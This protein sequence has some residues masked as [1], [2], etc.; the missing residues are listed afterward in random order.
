MVS[1]ANS[2]S[3]SRTSCL[4][5]RGFIV[6]SE[7]VAKEDDAEVLSI[8]GRE[9]RVTHPSKPYFT[10]ETKLSKLDVVRYYLAVAGGALNGIANRPAVLNRFVNAPAGKEFY[11]HR[12]PPNR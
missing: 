12:A 1:S 11:H 9:V 4:V 10:K 6:R 3:M 8:E 2:R 5:S 7:P